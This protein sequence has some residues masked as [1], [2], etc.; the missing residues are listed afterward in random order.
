[1]SFEVS[2][3]WPMVPTRPCRYCLSLQRDSVFADFEVDDEGRIYLVRIS[4]DGYGC[5]RIDEAR[6]MSYEESC[7]F[8]KWV[9]S[10]DVDHDAM[11]STLLKY[12]RENEDVIWKDALADH[13]L[14]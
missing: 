11:R 1:V 8:M 10:G 13:D 6:R 14:L 5:C 9:E 2:K 12:F 3:Y 4:F 7:N